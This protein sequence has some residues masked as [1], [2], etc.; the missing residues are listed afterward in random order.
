[1]GSPVAS[2][3]GGV[4]IPPS[5]EQA[6]R[7]ILEEMP[8]LADK[9]VTFYVHP[10]TQPDGSASRGGWTLLACGPTRAA[11]ERGH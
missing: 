3:Q 7:E 8:F 11:L 6:A 4:V 9:W 2:D 1:M 10:W 5:I